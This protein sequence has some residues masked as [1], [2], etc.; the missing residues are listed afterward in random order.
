VCAR[1]RERGERDPRGATSRPRW[2]NLGCGRATADRASGLHLG[3]SRDAQVPR[4]ACRFFRPRRVAYPAA[5]LWAKRPAH[6][7]RRA[8]GLTDPSL[9]SC[10]L[11]A[12]GSTDRRAK[13]MCGSLAL[14]RLSVSS[15]TSAS[16]RPTLALCRATED[17]SAA[18]IAI[19]GRSRAVRG[20]RRISQPPRTRDRKGR[21]MSRR[22]IRDRS[23]QAQRQKGMTDRE[24]MGR[25][26][27]APD[28][29][30]ACVCVTK[31]ASTAVVA[32]LPRVEEDE[33]PNAGILRP[34][35]LPTVHGQCAMRQ[36]ST[37][38]V[39]GPYRS[40]SA[41]VEPPSG[42][43]ARLSGCARAHARL[44]HPRVNETSRLCPRVILA[45]AVPEQASAGRR[46]EADD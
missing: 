6:P 39:P 29:L 4:S 41:R 9:A 21:A 16:R 10:R 19:G 46:Q 45:G 12:E 22:G 25:A 23:L 7:A 8:R 37:S 28:A 24:A 42:A 30:D 44:V 34:V 13:P 27:R 26:S 31:G 18:A 15:R 35:G 32:E 3:V 14:A 17:G 43:I 36:A 5:G 33:S 20:Y 40:T 11:P 1:F 2:R 38:G